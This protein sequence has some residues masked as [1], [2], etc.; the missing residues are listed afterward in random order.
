[1]EHAVL[2]FEQLVALLRCLHQGMQV[3]SVW[4]AKPLSPKPHAHEPF[5]RL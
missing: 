3:L 4:V 2:D 5:D 1:M